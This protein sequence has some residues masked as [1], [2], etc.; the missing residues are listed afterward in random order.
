MSSAQIVLKKNE[1]RRLRA[2]H[3][4]VFSNEVDSTR[5]DLRTLAAGEAVEVLDEHGKF[6]GHGYANPQSL[7]CARIVSRDKRYP[8]DRSLLV[9]RLNIALS[10]RE[11]LFDKPYYRLVHGEGDLL[12]GLIVDRFA[13]ALVVQLTTA[14]ME[15]RREMVIEALMKVLK[16]QTII[17]RNDGSLRELEGLKSY[18]ETVVGVTPDSLGLEENGVQ[19]RFPAIGGQ[20]TGWFY[21]HRMN[22][23]RMQ[24]YV[25]DKRVLDVFSYIG[26]WGIQAAVAGAADVMCVDSSSLALDQAYENAQLNGVESRFAALEGDAFEALKAL[27]EERERFDV[28]VLDPPAFMKRKKD[29]KKGLEAYQRINRMA[30][31][32]LAKDGILISASCSHHLQRDRLLEAML[33]GA[34]HLDREI[35]LLEQG[36]QGPD[37]PTHPAIPETEYLKCFT[38]RVLPAH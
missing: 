30:M 34:R 19:F 36:H 18:V 29:A 8:L 26:G 35:Q 15:S 24:H 14:G 11:R 2:G 4:W 20:K 17:L 21:D 22:R 16:P 1:A 12:P 27:R 32:V 31:Q 6:L 7:I 10:I 25:K 23:Q 37:H 3:L 13:D 28:V 33:K 9:H 5:T 38:A